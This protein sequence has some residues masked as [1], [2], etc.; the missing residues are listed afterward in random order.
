MGGALF[1]RSCDSRKLTFYDGLTFIRLPIRR[2]RPMVKKNISKYRACPP[3]KRTSERAL[4]AERPS[5]I[6]S[7]VTRL[8]ERHDKQSN[9]S[10]WPTLPDGSSLNNTRNDKKERVFHLN[11]GF[12]L[13]DVFVLEGEGGLRAMA[14][15]RGHYWNDEQKNR[16]ESANRT[17]K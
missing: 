16:A 3:H 5:D 13:M 8:S 10:E 12:R 1:Q 17:Q 14:V 9:V 4:P 7:A 2:E 11:C 15:K 6:C